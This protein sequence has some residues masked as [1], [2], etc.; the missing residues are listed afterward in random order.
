MNGTTATDGFP[1]APTLAVVTVTTS[2]RTPEGVPVSAPAAPADGAS[3]TDTPQAARAAL[4]SRVRLETTCM[5]VPFRSQRTTPG[6]REAGTRG[7][8]AHNAMA[9]ATLRSRDIAER[10]EGKTCSPDWS[11]D[12]AG[13]EPGRRAATAAGPGWRPAGVNGP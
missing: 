8:R 13:A 6:T 9:L 11:W 2:R 7:F 12:G 4:A 10:K 3:R 5:V 1:G